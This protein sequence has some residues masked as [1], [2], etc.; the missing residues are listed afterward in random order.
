MARCLPIETLFDDCVNSD[1]GFGVTLALS[2]RTMIAEERFDPVGEVGRL[3]SVDVD[4]QGRA[5]SVAV[6]DDKREFVEAIRVSVRIELLG[7]VLSEN[8]ESSI[9]RGTVH[10]STED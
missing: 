8:I 10:D 9:R 7:N 3:F 5:V 1:V 2:T 6:V 4:D